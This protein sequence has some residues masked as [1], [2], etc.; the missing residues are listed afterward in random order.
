MRGIAARV[1]KSHPLLIRNLPSAAKP[2]NKF[3]KLQILFSEMIQTPLVSR[4]TPQ[5][6]SAL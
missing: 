1:P 6:R 2:V 3:S 4:K 5:K